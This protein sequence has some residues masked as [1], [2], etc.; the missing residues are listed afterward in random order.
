MNRIPRGKQIT[1]DNKKNTDNK[2]EG[3]RGEH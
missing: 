1:E 3:V 2:A